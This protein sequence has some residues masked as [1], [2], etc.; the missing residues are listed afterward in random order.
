VTDL[1][2]DAERFVEEVRRGDLELASYLRV[3]ECEAGGIGVQLSWAISTMVMS[4]AR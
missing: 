2:H 3:E 1:R 4:H